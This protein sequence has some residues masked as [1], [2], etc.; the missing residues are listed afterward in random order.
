[1]GIDRFSDEMLV[2]QTIHFPN[3]D[4]IF[5][6]DPAGNHR[7]QTDEKTCFEI[8]QAKG[9][10][11]EPGMQTLNLRLEC[12]RKPLRTLVGGKPQFVLNPRC[13]GL[14]RGFLG[15]YQFRR[16]QIS[17]TNRFTEVPDKSPL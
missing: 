2:H 1:M 10:P 11:I 16:M 5:V 14:R 15:G 7:S 12:V 13:K 8:L 4:F 9:I 17:G 6:G 3:R